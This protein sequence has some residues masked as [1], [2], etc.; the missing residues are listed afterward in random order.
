[1]I[2]SKKRTILKKRVITA[3]TLNLIFI[4]NINCFFCDF[5]AP[6]DTN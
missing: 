4:C 5:S 6:L 2:F 1:M 3:F